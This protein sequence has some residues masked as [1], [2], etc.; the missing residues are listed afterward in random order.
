MHLLFKKINGAKNE[1]NKT[2]R[3]KHSPS[4]QV[5]ERTSSSEKGRGDVLQVIP[6]PERRKKEGK[7]KRQA[8]GENTKYV[9]RWFHCHS[10]Q[11]IAERLVSLSFSNSASFCSRPFWNG[12]VFQCK[13]DEY[14]GLPLR[15]ESYLL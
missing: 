8:P 6:R 9:R 7:K 12:S 14:M 2:A 4:L 11:F 1:A 10:G 5:C 15:Q 13:K 3:F